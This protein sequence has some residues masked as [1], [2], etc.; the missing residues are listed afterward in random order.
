MMDLPEMDGAVRLANGTGTACD[1]LHSG[2]VEV[3][4]AAA[5]AWGAICTAATPDD[6]LAADVICRQLGFPHGT[7]EMPRAGGTGGVAGVGGFVIGD[8]ACRGV[9]ERIGECRIA[10]ERAG[11]SGSA[12][13]RKAARLRVACR[14][15]PVAEALESVV[16]PGAGAVATHALHAQVLLLQRRTVTFALTPVAAHLHSHRRCL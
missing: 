6:R 14:K 4:D 1:D 5:D 7:L 2:V 16:T 11:G 8:V 15:F 13:M 3:Y 9:E 12:C 10:P